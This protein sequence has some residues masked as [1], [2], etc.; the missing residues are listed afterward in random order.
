MFVKFTEPNEQNHPHL[1]L[2]VAHRWS[3]LNSMSCQISRILAY[4]QDDEAYVL[5]AQVYHIYDES[6]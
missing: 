1:N 4:L 3:D 5:H 2:I 6:R